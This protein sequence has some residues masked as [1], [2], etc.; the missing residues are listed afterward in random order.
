MGQTPKIVTQEYYL[1]M[2]DSSVTLIGQVAIVTLFGAILGGKPLSGAYPKTKQVELPIS[3]NRRNAIALTCKYRQQFYRR[4]KIPIQH[5]L[6]VMPAAVWSRAWAYVLVY[7]SRFRCFSHIP[8][9]NC[10]GFSMKIKIS[11]GKR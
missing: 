7:I 5:A 8:F 11:F 6:L 10:I 3:T 4:P 1:Q 9:D 2:W